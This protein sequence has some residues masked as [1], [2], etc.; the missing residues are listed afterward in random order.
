MSFFRQVYEFLKSASIAHA[1]WDYEVSTS[2]LKNRKKMLWIILA[3]LPILVVAMAE[4]GGILGGKTAYAPAFYSTKIFVVSIAIGLAAG[5]ITGCIG[6]G[7]GFIITPALMAAGV[8]GIL[9]VGTD[10]FH[11]FAKAIMGTTVHKKLGN[12]SVKLAVAFLVGSTGGAVIGGLINKGLYDYD[13]LLSEAFIS[14]IYA[15]L[16]GF[17]G[18]YSLAD[19]LKSRKVADTGDAHGAPAEVPAV[20]IKVQSMNIPPMITFDEDYVPGGRKISGVIV[21]AG[22]VIVGIM[23]A[24]MGVGGG[25]ITFPMFVY[26]FG[27]SSMT[28]VGT[29]ILQIIFTAGFAAVTQYAIYGYVFYTLAMGMLLGSLIGIQVGAMTTKVVKG[30]HIRG[31]YAISI[32]AGFINRVSTLPKKLTEL[33]IIN[34][35]KGLSTGIEVSGNVIFWLVVGFFAFWIFSKFFGNMKKFKEGV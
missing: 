4:A 35:P 1:K 12:V 18:F 13:P 30:I 15:A 11:I 20:T 3:I 29:D 31:F 32:L 16:L 34:V 7:G 21:A 5:L 24:I 2:I 8:K 26:I 6:A 25:F 19:F 17:L 23:A 27:V 10:L 22:G 33:E 28:T 9:A 14:L